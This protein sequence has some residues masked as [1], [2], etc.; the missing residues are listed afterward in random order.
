MC[1]GHHG[2]HS[3]PG[4]PLLEL[5]VN[6]HVTPNGRSLNRPQELSLF[7][8]GGL[9]GEGEGGQQGMLGSGEKIH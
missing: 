1:R 7:R 8:R 4:P 3:S 5:A 9:R 2:R 6:E